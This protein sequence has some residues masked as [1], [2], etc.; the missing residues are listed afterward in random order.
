MAKFYGTVGF[1]HS[2]E[3]KDDPSVWED[4]TVEKPYQG[5]LIKD[6]FRYQG[7]EKLNDNINVDNQMSILA[8][9]YAFENL[10]HIQWVELPGV[11]WKINSTQIAYPRITLNIGGV[12]NE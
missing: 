11:T 2:E 9:P 8:D 6:S 10:N 1:V 4:V 3:R 7:A 5:E 12:Y